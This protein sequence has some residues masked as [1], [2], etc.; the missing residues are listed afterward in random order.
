MRIVN[1]FVRHLYT[2]LENRNRSYITLRE[3]FETRFLRQTLTIILKLILKA[4]WNKEI[5][6]CEHEKKLSVLYFNQ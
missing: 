2:R 4:V 3:Y 1:L 5:R 6:Y